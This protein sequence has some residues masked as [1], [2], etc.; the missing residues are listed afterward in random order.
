[1]R[2]R[3]DF[4]ARMSPEDLARRMREVAGEGF[5]VQSGGDHLAVSV[6]GEERHFWSPWLDGHIYATD[7]GCAFRGRFM[8]HPN[9]WT[10]Y[11]FAYA[12]TGILG[13]IAATLG[14]VQWVLGGTPWGLAAAGGAVGLVGLLFASAF[15]GQRLGA[16]Q[17]HLLHAIADTAAAGD[18]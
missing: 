18:S 12:A 10:G 3:F 6:V 4:E 17:M 7:D 11:L 15:V 8:P 16:A 13:S 5:R 14:C 1:M 2:P 9:I